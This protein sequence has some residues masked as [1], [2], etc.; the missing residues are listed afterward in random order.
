MTHI[1]IPAVTP[2]VQYTCNGTQ[3]VFD[4]P[5]P[6]FET[7]DLQVL[8]DGVPQYAGY[9]I[10]GA[11]T[12]GGGQITF[13][14]A[15]TAGVILSLARELAIA[16]VSDFTE[17]SSFAAATLNTELDYNVAA[18]QQ[19]SAQQ[20]TMLRYADSEI[21]PNTY[22]PDRATRANQVLG[23][24]GDGQ[25]ITYPTAA[26]VGATPYTVTGTG[27]TARAIQDRLNEIVSIKDFGAV[28]DGVADDTL[29]IQHA[30]AAHQKVFVPSGTYRI[31]S[32]LTVGNAQGLFGQGNSS[33]IH[34]DN[35]SFDI[36]QLPAGYAQI[37]NLKLENGNAGIRLFGRDNVCVENSITDVNI[38]T[39][40]YGLVLDGYTDTNLPCY[41][42]HFTRILIAQPKHT[43]VWLTQSGAGD[44]PNANK[45]HGVRVYSLGAAISNDGFY[46]EYGR[47]N[48]S[49][50]DCEANID[51]SG[52]ICFHIGAHTDK[53]LFINP[54]AESLG[55]LANFQLEAGSQNT[56]IINLLSEAAG[57]AIYDFSG[58]SYTAYN[59]GY[60][61]KNRLQNTIA[62]D[63]T[64]Q[65]LRYDTTY[66]VQS[67]P[68]TLTVD[69]TSSVYLVSAYG[70][71]VDVQLPQ[72]V[73]ANGMQLTIKKIDNTP[74]LVVIN[75]TGGP[76]PD[77]R[78]VK[79]GSEY[80]FVTLVSNGAKWWMVSASIVP[81]NTQYID[82][83]TL[84][85]PDLSRPIYLVSAYSGAG[86]F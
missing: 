1:Q 53:N 19:V 3:T 23:F 15:P 38:W 75:E 27:A 28:G 64:V 44:T 9:E 59:A 13:T 74:N 65:T 14:A 33:I 81:V 4:Y 46:V 6:I 42:N 16:R 11:G 5:F 76:G 77:D 47:Y 69:Q 63:F 52:Q 45:F 25:L 12:S 36:I 56:C 43:G 34:A 2:R 55:A 57:P 29:A 51:A 60:P 18:I 78:V 20:N 40:N 70:G 72:A 17:G 54:Y 26:P 49:F 83:Q 8:F 21:A 66:F 68:S 79:L 41:W 24:N 30:L 61:N 7:A 82:S 62:T 37:H 35:N 71:E 31:T 85:Q 86:E 50:I 67:T 10:T 32:T 39:A 80:D 73:N 48:N 84:I 22:L 58:G